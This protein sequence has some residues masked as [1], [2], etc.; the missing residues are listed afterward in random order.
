MMLDVQP[1][2][3]LRLLISHF[4][5]NLFLP[6][7]S[8]DNLVGLPLGNNI[9]KTQSYVKLQTIDRVLVTFDTLPILISPIDEKE[10]GGY[11]CQWTE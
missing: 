7:M 10:G 3:P 4:Y 5:L 8:R 9:K 11:S 2:Q 1:L 6:A